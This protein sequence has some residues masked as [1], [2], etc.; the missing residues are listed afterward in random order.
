L[1][2]QP[3]QALLMQLV[4]NRLHLKY[5]RGVDFL[6]IDRVNLKKNKL[7]TG[8]PQDLADAENI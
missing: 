6:I 3:G 1:A 5:F 2:L 8:R 4:L 7:A